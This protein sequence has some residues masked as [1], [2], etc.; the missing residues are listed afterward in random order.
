M[1]KIEEIAAAVG[2][3]KIK[4][5]DELVQSAIDAGEDPM[6]ILN[7]GMVQAMSAIGE[8]FSRGEAFVPEMLI[9]ARTMKKGVEVLKPHLAKDATVA[10]GTC[11][12]GTVHGDMHDIG[13]NLVAMMMESAGVEIVDLEID[14]P[15]ERFVEA[16]QTH[17]HVRIVALSTLLTTTMPAMKRIVGELNKLENRSSFKILVGGS[18]V[19]EEFARSIGADGYSA[20]AA[21]AAALAKSFVC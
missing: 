17:D 7:S 3:G 21:A 4:I 14:V 5:I 15:L 1:T 2:A 13:K 6:E 12:I 18:P 11:V 16:I 8:R 10:C 9:S 20:D 19:T